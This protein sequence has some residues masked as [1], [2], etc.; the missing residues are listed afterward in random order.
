MVLQIQSVPA[1]FPERLLP[2]RE[3]IGELALLKGVRGE[4][5]VF[6]P[7]IHVFK[8]NEH[9]ELTALWCAEQQRG[10]RRCIR[11]LADR[12]GARVMGERSRVHLL[13]ELVQ[14]RAICVE[15]MPDS[16]ALEM[17]SMASTRKPSTPRSSHQFIIS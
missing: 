5:P 16:G 14:A 17:T 6:E 9:V 11:G 8:L 10:L 13:Q 12:E 7:Q 3:D 15:L 4:L 2:T 1:A